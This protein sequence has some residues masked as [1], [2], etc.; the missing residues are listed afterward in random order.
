MFYKDPYIHVQKQIDALI[1]IIKCIRKGDCGKASSITNVIGKGHLI[2]KHNDGNGN[3]VDIKE[4]IT[5]LS[6]DGDIISYVKEDGSVD[7]IDVITEPSS[8]T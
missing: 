2:A 6:L 8:F 3:E 7:K 1:K 5:S 4:T